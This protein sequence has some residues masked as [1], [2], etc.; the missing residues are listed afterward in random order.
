MAGKLTSQKEGGKVEESQPVR[1]SYCPIRIRYPVC[2][3]RWFMRHY[4]RRENKKFSISLSSCAYE[5][6]VRDNVLP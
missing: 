5:Q 6:L 4:T 3:G 1:S 2:L